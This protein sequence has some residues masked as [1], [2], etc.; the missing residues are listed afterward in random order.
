MRVFQDD[1]PQNGETYYETPLLAMNTAN[2][3][4]GIFS[5]CI[6]I[7]SSTA[8][9]ALDRLFGSTEIQNVEFNPETAGLVFAVPNGYALWA[10]YGADS[11]LPSSDWN[12]QKLVE[13]THY[14]N[15]NNV[16]TIR[17]T[18]EG[19]PAFRVLRLGLIHDF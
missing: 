9:V 1:T 4:D 14:S 8:G 6:S 11:V 7:G 12:W 13:G 3:Q 16:V 17:T 19:L 2:A 18:G 10:V 5:Q 15:E